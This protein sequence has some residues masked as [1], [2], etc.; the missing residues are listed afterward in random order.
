MSEGKEIKFEYGFQSVNGIVK[1]KYY[2]HEIPN[3]RE[4]CDVWNQLPI[5]YVRQYTG[6]K[7][8]NGVE[9]YE[10]DKVKGKSKVGVET[11]VFSAIYYSND[12]S[13]SWQGIGFLLPEDSH[14][15]E[16]EIIGNIY[17]K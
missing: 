7:D 13:C 8:K 12:Y 3:I 10:G 1:K 6:L 11:M 2:L 14:P 16:C 5:L 9:I 4:K 17:E 15:E